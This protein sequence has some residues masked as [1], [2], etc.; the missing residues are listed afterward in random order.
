M[1]AS[2]EK[3]LDALAMQI[4]AL[5][6]GETLYLG[7]FNI[8]NIDGGY[9]FSRMLPRTWCNYVQFELVVLPASDPHLAAEGY[10]FDLALAYAAE[11][12]VVKPAGEPLHRLTADRP[13]TT[14]GVTLRLVVPLARGVVP[15]DQEYDVKAESVETGVTVRIGVVYFNADLPIKNAF[16]PIYGG[17]IEHAREVL[18]RMYWNLRSVDAELS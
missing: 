12:P 16:V 1:N 10:G 15:S 17:H 9:Y 11:K 8:T 7:V 5:K 3:R 14:G 18:D 13:I 6:N 4:A 2:D